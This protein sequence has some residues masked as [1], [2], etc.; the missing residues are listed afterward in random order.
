M[1]SSK[2]PMSLETN[3]RVPGLLII[4]TRSR[5]LHQLEISWFVSNVACHLGD[6]YNAWIGAT[7]TQSIKVIERQ[8]SSLY[9]ALDK[10]DRLYDWGLNAKQLFPWLVCQI[11]KGWVRNELEQLK[12][13]VNRVWTPVVFPK[14]VVVEVRL[15]VPTSGCLEKVF[16][17]IIGYYSGLR[18]KRM[19][20]I[21][22]HPKLSNHFGSQGRLRIRLPLMDFFQM[23]NLKGRRPVVLCGLMDLLQQISKAHRS[24]P[25]R[26]WELSLVYCTISE[27]A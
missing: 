13:R 21:D 7:N 15:C 1:P 10:I 22:V 3:I 26:G 9:C 25:S 8:E 14:Q 4:D 23:V 16:W 24:S 27:S 18:Q 19:S 6:W 5:V 2:K 11:K 17:F 20:T 12:S